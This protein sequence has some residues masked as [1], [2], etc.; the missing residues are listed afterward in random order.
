MHEMNLVRNLVGTIL[1]G[2]K[3]EA[4]GELPI[5]EV[6]MKV[7][8]LELHSG[9]AFRQAFEVVSR[10]TALEG[11]ELRLTIMPAVLKCGDC[12]HE[13]ACGD[14]ELDVHD[15]MPFAECPKCGRVSVVTGGRGVDGIEVKFR[16]P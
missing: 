15:P 7:G 14:G 12:G 9:E 16:D 4:Q 3:K 5:G 6:V 8:A 10:G 13:S 1:D 11:A 2:L